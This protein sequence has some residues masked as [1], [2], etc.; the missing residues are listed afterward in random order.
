MEPTEL[1]AWDGLAVLVLVF[2]AGICRFVAVVRYA[3]RE[4]EEKQKARQAKLAGHL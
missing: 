4:R 3:L 1:A 2:V